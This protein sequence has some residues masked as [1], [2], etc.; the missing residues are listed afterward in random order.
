MFGFGSQFQRLE[1]HCQLSPLP[2]VKQNIV[3]EESDGAELLTSQQPGSRETQ[4]RIK[5]QGTLFNGMPQ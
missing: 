1:I 4:E 3:V 5:E 2:E